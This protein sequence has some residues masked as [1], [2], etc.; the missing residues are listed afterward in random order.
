MPRARCFLPPLFAAAWARSD[1]RVSSNAASRLWRPKLRRFGAT[2]SEVEER[3]STRFRNEMEHLTQKH[4]VQWELE[5]VELHDRVKELVDL[6]DQL[7]KDEVEAQ[8]P[9]VRQA[10]HDFALALD[11]VSRGVLGQKPLRTTASWAPL[12]LRFRYYICSLFSWGLLTE[13]VAQEAAKVL[14]ELGVKGV[15]DPLAGSGWQAMLWEVAGGLHVIALDSYEA[16]SVA[17][18]GVKLVTDSRR[19]LA[20]PIDGD[21]TSW[22]LLLSWPP[23]S[24]ES[25]GLDLL[26]VWHGEFLIYLGERALDDDDGP[27][28]GQSLL[29]AIQDDW[30]L[31]Q[32]YRIPSWPGCKDD[33]TIYRRRKTE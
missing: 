30:D 26:R 15:V 25:V 1:G 6:V 17:W 18:S 16:K 11:V 24:P 20:E 28:P 22:A 4:Q 8:L 31:L 3:L 5:L 14:K 32:R 2:R 7:K 9:A 19:A 29:D 33:L 23:H 27:W 12:L 13:E 10:Y 21:L